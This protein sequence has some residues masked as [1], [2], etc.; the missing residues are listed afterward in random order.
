M[1]EKF[2]NPYEKGDDPK[3][4]CYGWIS[5]LLDYHFL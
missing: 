1:M 3:S 2:I 5:Q 4:Q